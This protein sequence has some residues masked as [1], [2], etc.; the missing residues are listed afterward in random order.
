MKLST[1]VCAIA[2]A[3]L[4]MSSLSFAQGRG[5][6]RRG[7]GDDRH[8]AQR[9]GPPHADQRNQQRGPNRAEPPRGQ[10]SYEQPDMRRNDRNNF[11]NARGP[12][13]RRGGHIQREY[14]SRQYVV[15]DYRTHRLSPPPRGQQWVQVG[16][17]Y[18]LIAIATGLIAQIVLGR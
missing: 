9:Q 3:S 5:D 17:D 14:R 1:I 8:Q 7:G 10:I 12:E 15:S 13:F 18:V 6:D 16:A 4:G 2:V 11:Y